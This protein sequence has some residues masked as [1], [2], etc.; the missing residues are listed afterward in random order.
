MAKKKAP[1]TKVEKKEK[2]ESLTDLKKRF[3]MRR[4]M[5]QE[6]RKNDEI[7]RVK[8]KEEQE[9]IKKEKE[10]K[11]EREKEEREKE[12][13][14]KER[15]EK[16]KRQQI[17]TLKLEKE[18]EELQKEKITQEIKN[19]DPEG[20]E[21]EV[22]VEEIIHP[23]LIE[24]A[25]DTKIEENQNQ[26]K[27]KDKIPVKVEKEKKSV[28]ITTQVNNKQNGAE[29]KIDN[30]T[31]QK[32]KSEIHNGE[33]DEAMGADQHIPKENQS[34]ETLIKTAELK[35]QIPKSNMTQIE[36]SNHINSKTEN[37][38]TQKKEEDLTPK[39]DQES[40]KVS[41]PNGE[42]KE[43]KKQE[44][45]LDLEREDLNLKQIE[46][47]ELGKRQKLELEKKEKEDKAEFIRNL[48]I[49][50]G[51]MA[52]FDRKRLNI[53]IKFSRKN[54]NSHITQNLRVS[55]QTHFFN[56][57]NPLLQYITPTYSE[58]YSTYIQFNPCN[59][60]IYLYIN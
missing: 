46:N 38:S 18:K 54:Q 41:I 50:V 28:E 29:N 12:E 7:Q 39:I 26:E 20:N 55:L 22:Q 15:V 8:E 34:N 52:T 56:S 32:T 58:Y 31:Q 3:L 47:T 17:E 14:E 40:G 2:E 37:N 43:I 13:K 44:N 45:E 1:N 4:R 9:K 5:A 48:K 60:Y 59:S 16:E 25:Q 24:T 53:K 11:E 36:E 6:K 57:Q 21:T 35:N 10:E 23:G 19:N 30:N 33:M 27:E 42:I 49:D 51:K